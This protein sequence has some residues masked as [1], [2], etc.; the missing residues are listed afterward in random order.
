MREVERAPASI[1]AVC[2]SSLFRRVT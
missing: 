2:R 1:L